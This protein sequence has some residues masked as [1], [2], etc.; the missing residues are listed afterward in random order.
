MEYFLYILA[1]VLI[2]TYF[3]SRS[4]SN[5][6]KLYDYYGLNDVST[7]VLK[8]YCLG[9]EMSLNEFI[10]FWSY[11]NLNQSEIDLLQELFNKEIEYTGEEI[12]DFVKKEN[13]K[14]KLKVINGGI[15]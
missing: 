12:I 15:K 4:K 14:K 13:M 6:S 1:I 10:N 9:I 2:I 3:L 8:R 7:E 5:V 11:K